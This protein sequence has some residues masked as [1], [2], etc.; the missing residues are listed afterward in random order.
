MRPGFSTRSLSLAAALAAVGTLAGAANAFTIGMQFVDSD[1]GYGNNPINGTTVGAP[2]YTQ[3]AW[4]TVSV[5]DHG[6]SSSDWSQTLPSLTDST[7]AMVPN[8]AA[9]FS[10]Q[11]THVT[12]TYY[13]YPQAGLTADEKFL[14]AG[15]IGFGGGGDIGFSNLP[16]GSYTMVLYTPNAY[17]GVASFA[18]N[19]G[20][21]TSIYEQYGEDF[22]T[23][24]DV[25][26]TNPGNTSS[27]S[28]SNYLV[29]TGLT[30][31]NTGS[32]N[33]HYAEVSG[34]DVSVSAVQL[35][36][37]PVPEPASLSLLG[38]AGGM[39]LLRRRRS[40]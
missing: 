23:S 37:A 7:G 36:S 17:P 22:S 24:G 19:G 31:D 18:V 30:P 21:A 11:G 12:Q 13:T 4:N 35:I 25:Y 6:G 38:A 2:G 28:P 32:I 9:S 40:T 26:V 34:T 1:N 33:L 27:S 14:S 8:V 10:S 16:A 5:H 29:L 15:I 3:A 39:L 20:T